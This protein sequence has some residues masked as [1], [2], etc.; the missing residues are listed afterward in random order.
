[1]DPETIKPQHHKILPQNPSEPE[2]S[3]GLSAAAGTSFT[4]A[5]SCPRLY[6]PWVVPKGSRPEEGC[7][8]LPH[9]QLPSLAEHPLSPEARGWRSDPYE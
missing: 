6:R 4:A 2:L 1:M 3:A 7:S 9:P 5:A 8:H